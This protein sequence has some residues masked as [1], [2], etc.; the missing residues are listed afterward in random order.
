M[1]NQVF[2]FN[3]DNAPLAELAKIHNLNFTDHWDEETFEAL[4]TSFGTAGIYV[5]NSMKEFL[6]FILYRQAF[7]DAEILTI[8]VH[9][10]YH[11][12]GVGSLLVS[13]LIEA[14]EKPGKCFLEVSDL[15]FS[16]IH[17]YEKF[18]FKN[19]YTRKNYYGDQKDAYMMMIEFLCS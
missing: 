19:V 4:L 14:L 7:S 13:S 16:A 18:G 9:P 5:K 15:N 11:N 12:K 17:L 3:Y 8:S 2:Y 6:G 1:K 10:D